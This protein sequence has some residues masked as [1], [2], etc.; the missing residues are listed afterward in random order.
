MSLK[1]KLAN[2]EPDAW[3]KRP[4]DL[5][6]HGLIVAGYFSLFMAFWIVGRK[7]SFHL[8]LWLAGVGAALQL[9]HLLP[10]LSEKPSPTDID[11]P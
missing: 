2:L 5:L 6:R 7:G 4:F 1:D 8:V 10:K 3:A 11:S 9:A